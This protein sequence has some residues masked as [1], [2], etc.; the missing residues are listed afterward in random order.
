M[1]KNSALKKSGQ[2]T[3]SI[4]FFTGSEM[5][6]INIHT[7]YYYKHCGITFISVLIAF[8]IL[9]VGIITLL[10]VYPVIDKL[11]GRAKTY[12]SLS[13]IADKVFTTIEKIY[14]DADGPV[15]PS[16]L[17]GTDEDFPQYSYFVNIQQEKEDLYK[18]EVKITRMEEGKSESDYFYGSFRRQ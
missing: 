9:S 6:K 17:S 7:P 15:V 1:I 13:M 12:V 10:R 16:F 4:E 11:S 14:G 18:A 5:T 3:G 8:F 2:M